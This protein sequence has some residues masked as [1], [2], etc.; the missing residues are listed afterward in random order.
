MSLKFESSQLIFIPTDQRD[1]LYAGLNSASPI[2]KYTIK[3]NDS[4]ESTSEDLIFH[5][6]LD[7]DIDN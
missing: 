4:D 6:D 1:S 7:E 2:T 3:Y 5:I